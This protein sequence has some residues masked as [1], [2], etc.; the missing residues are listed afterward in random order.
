MK[1]WV[2]ASFKSPQVAEALT[3]RGKRIYDKYGSVMLNTQGMTSAGVERKAT[4]R[5]LFSKLLYL[6]G[7]DPPP[8]IFIQGECPSSP[9]SLSG[10]STPPP[11]P[12]HLSHLI[13]NGMS[14]VLQYKFSMAG[15]AMLSFLVVSHRPKRGK[16]GGGLSPLNTGG[17]THTREGAELALSH[18][19]T[20]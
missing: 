16:R 19:C 10:R 9:S 1:L 8:L 5:A 11:P 13:V 18:M 17:S 12:H 15:Q 6:A 20:S 3:E 2:K 4:A 7:W 14:H